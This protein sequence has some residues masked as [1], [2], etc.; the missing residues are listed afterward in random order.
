MY[1]HDIERPK[2]WFRV[3]RYGFGWNMP[4][5]WQGTLVYAIY[6]TL[7]VAGGVYTNL[8]HELTRYAF[9]AYYVMITAALVAVCWNK[10]DK[11][12]RWRWGDDD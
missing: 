12:P 1:N 3:R 10:S 8:H 7:A 6:A 11:A 9:A 2:P 4:L 5:T